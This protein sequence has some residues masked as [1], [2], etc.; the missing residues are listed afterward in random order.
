MLSTYCNVDVLTEEIS[1]GIC[2]VCSSDV[3]MV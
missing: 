1:F 2:G 3:L